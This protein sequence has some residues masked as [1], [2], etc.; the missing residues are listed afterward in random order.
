MSEVIGVSAEILR[1]QSLE[2]VVITA[3][4]NCGAPGVY[5]SEISIAIGWPKCYV[6]PGDHRDTKTVGDTC[7]ECGYLRNPD[8]D[9]GEIWSREWR[10]KKES[11]FQRFLSFFQGIFG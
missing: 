4:P 8:R 9:L 10:Y 1:R 3:C 11:I 7:P 5:K 2:A 6:S